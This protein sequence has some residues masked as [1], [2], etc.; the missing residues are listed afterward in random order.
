MP[1]YLSQLNGNPE[2]ADAERRVFVPNQSLLARCD[3]KVIYPGFVDSRST[4]MQDGQGR[5]F[6]VHGVDSREGSFWLEA[7]TREPDLVCTPCSP[8]WSA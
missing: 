6:S 3:G 8:V 1:R 5:V 7:A 4:Y 2:T